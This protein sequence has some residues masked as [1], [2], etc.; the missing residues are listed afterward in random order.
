MSN[1]IDRYV[2]QFIQ[3]TVSWSE[4]LTRSLTI[5]EGY[6]SVHHNKSVHHIICISL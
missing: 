6:D 5:A 3:Y 2:A 4:R 1:L